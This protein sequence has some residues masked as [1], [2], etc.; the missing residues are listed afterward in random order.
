MYE[1]KVPRQQFSFCRSVARTCFAMNHIEI[2]DEMLAGP[3]SLVYV[4]HRRRVERRGVRA[5][6]VGLENR[7]ALFTTT[8]IATHAADIEIGAWR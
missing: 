2:T 7:R 6:G 3:K 5:G 8:T 1:M 4:Q